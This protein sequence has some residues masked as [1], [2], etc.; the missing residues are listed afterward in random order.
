MNFLL[1]RMENAQWETNIHPEIKEEHVLD[2]FPAQSLLDFAVNQPGFRQLIEEITNTGPLRR[3]KG[4][5]YRMIPGKGHYDKWHTDVPHFQ[6]LVGMTLNLS[7]EVFRGGLFMMR[8]RESK[9]VL[10]EIANTGLG[11]ALI[12]RITP[13]LEHRVSDV[14]GDKAKTAFAGWFIADGVEFFEE[15]RQDSEQYRAATSAGAATHKT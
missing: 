4:R 5:V 12:F 13:A 2:D 6:R 8:E 7:P 1:R 10:A 11:D 14:E 3:F 15:L 9:R